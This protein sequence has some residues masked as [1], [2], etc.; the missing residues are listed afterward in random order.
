MSP[1][2]N[3]ILRILFGL[4]FAAAGLWCARM[5]V[6]AWNRRSAWRREG[7]VVDGEIV[8]F[9]EVASNDPK[10]RRPTFAPV[11]TFQTAEGHPGR[12]T[13]ARSNRPNPY[14][15]GQP[16]AVRYKALLP[17][18]AELDSVTGSLFV[19]FALATMAVAF[20]AVAVVPAV[21]PMPVPRP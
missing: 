20:L 21:M 14:T 16:V 17:S 11:V 1:L 8:G 9:E 12:F 19:F 6:M 18:E 10:D 4:A 2:T 15:V 7:V 5:A 3:V 13:S